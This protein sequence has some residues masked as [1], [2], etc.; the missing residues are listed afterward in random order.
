MNLLESI[1]LDDVIEELTAGA[2]FQ[3]EKNF[4]LGFDFFVKSTNVRMLQRS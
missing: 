2:M 4:V 1:F 3:D